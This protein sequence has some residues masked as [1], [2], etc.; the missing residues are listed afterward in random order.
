MQPQQP[1]R[2]F[3][4]QSALIAQLTQPSMGQAVNPTG[5]A[6]TGQFNQGKCSHFCNIVAIG[7]M[8]LVCKNCSGG[9]VVIYLWVCFVLQDICCSMVKTLKS[10]PLNVLA[11]FL[12]WQHF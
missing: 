8:L 10:G 1:S 5:L 3:P 7:C 6:V 2:Q 4:N 11:N 9:E 12:C